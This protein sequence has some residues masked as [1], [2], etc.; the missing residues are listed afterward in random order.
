MFRDERGNFGFA[1]ANFSLTIGGIGVNLISPVAMAYTNT[2]TTSFS[3]RAQ[4]ESSYSLKNTTLFIWNSTNNLVYNK[5]KNISGFDNS[6]TFNYNLTKIGD[7]KWNCLAYNNHS[8]HTFA[9]ANYSITFDVT[10]PQVNLV[11]PA[12]G[13]SATAG[14]LS[15]RYN[16][17]DG[18]NL[19]SCGLILNGVV[20]A[21]NVSVITNGTNII[22]YV[23]SAGS[24]NWGVN[25]TDLAGNEGNSSVRGLVISAPPEIVYTSSGRGG[26]GAGP[27]IFY[28]TSSQVWSGYTKALTSGE[29]ISFGLGA[30][31][32]KHT[33]TVK[34][35]KEN[36]AN[37]TI[38]SNPISLTLF[39]GQ[40]VKLNLSSS[41]VYNLYLKLE[42]ISKG[43]VNVTM[44]EL[45]EKIILVEDEIPVAENNFVAMENETEEEGINWAEREK[46]MARVG[47]IVLIGFILFVIVLVFLIVRHQKL[48]EIT[49]VKKKQKR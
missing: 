34:E 7:Y 10:I 5:T 40:E 44:K 8:N 33:L 21:Y 28:P 42:G 39:V 14:S 15:F 47:I 36:Y 3:C 22:S 27:N 41:E 19:S 43:K 23:T 38:Q 13:Y 26:G 45:N 48:V 16:V 37:I 1:N 32:E 17:S 2:N 25:C 9:E 31:K 46:E 6:T 20:V 49:K 12:G 30:G 11:E 4:S 35:V 18:I 24:Y 29:K